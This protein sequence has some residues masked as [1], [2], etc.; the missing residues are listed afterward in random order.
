M[1]KT[2][3]FLMTFTLMIFAFFTYE[4][5]TFDQYL[6]H[7]HEGELNIP[8][9]AEAPVMSR[10]QLEIDAP[11]ETLWQILTNIE[12]W[13]T[14]QKA[15]TETAL[16]GKIKEGADFNWKADG[17]SFKSKIHTVKPYSQFGWTGSTFG[18]SA[19]HNWTFVEKEGKT[20]L[21]VE[22][23]LQGVLPRLFRSFFQKNLDTGVLTNLTELKTAAEAKT[24][25]ASALIN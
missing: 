13:P 7:P 1:K 11:V 18:A 8:I 4:N 15:V 14:W 3:L 5:Y 6:N 19:I 17:L 20:L 24:L 25:E 2:L 9:N 12:D 21:I 16:L 22:E 10:N 23:S